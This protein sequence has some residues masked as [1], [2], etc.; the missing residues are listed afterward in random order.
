[1]KMN[2]G[3]TKVMVIAEETKNIDIYV[4]IGNAKIKVNTLEYLGG[5]IENKWG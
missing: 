4:Y 3:K 5:I 2:K 1:M